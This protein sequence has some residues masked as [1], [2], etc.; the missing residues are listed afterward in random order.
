LRTFT[1]QAQSWTHSV[2]YAVALALILPLLAWG[3]A[4]AWAWL[5]GTL[6]GWGT[7]VGGGFAIYMVVFW[8]AG[9]FYIACDHY[10]W[11]A[12]KKIQPRAPDKPRSGPALP[13][14]IRVVLRNQLL[15]TLPVLF[16]L[17]PLMLWRGLDMTAAPDPW[18][19]IL[20]HLGGLVLIEELGFYS[21]H[22]A[23]HYKPLFKRFHRVHHEFRESIGITT[24]YVHY[25]EHLVGNLGPIFLG[26]VI[27]CPHP[28]TIFLWVVLG[29][30]NAIHTHAGYAFKWMVWPHDH[31]F[32]HFNVTG[33]YGVLGVLDRLFGTDQAFVEVARKQ[34]G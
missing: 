5:H 27:L 14:T 1:Y 20:L 12:D 28:V 7:F 23:L 2:S 33:N 18:W 30:A 9:G 8:L 34:P 24:H 15:G 13:K 6:G 19:V 25:V 21:A 16:A 10:R 4:D 31:D 32:H 22:R 26:V 3:G 17:Y 11:F 29:V